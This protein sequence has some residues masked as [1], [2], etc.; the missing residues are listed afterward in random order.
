VRGGLQGPSFVLVGCA[1]VLVLAVGMLLAGFAAI[2]SLAR[3]GGVGGVS[4]V[5]G[6][7]GA[8]TGRGAGRV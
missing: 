8:I 6:V 7:N 2:M 3:C 1:A 5:N 4:G